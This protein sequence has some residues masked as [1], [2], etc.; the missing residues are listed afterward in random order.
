[1]EPGEAVSGAVNGRIYQAAV[2]TDGAA[3][4]TRRASWF[5]TPKR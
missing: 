5:I 2:K 4:T 3:A 1:M